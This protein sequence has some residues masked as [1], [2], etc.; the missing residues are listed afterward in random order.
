MRSMSEAPRGPL[1][2]AVHKVSREVIPCKI[3]LRC[4]FPSD[5]GYEHAV[6]LSQADVGMA[7]AWVGYVRVN[8]LA[9][10]WPMPTEEI[11]EKIENPDLTS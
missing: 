7:S 3:V 8:D 5:G 6:R 4:T 1:I 10:W 2:L 9:G 11:C